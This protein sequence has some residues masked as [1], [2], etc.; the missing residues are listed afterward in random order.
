MEVWDAIHYVRFE[1]FL[2]VPDAEKRRLCRS[3]LD[4]NFCDA[5]IPK[6]MINVFQTNQQVTLQRFLSNL[7]HKKQAQRR[8]PGKDLELVLE[9]YWEE[10]APEFSKRMLR[11]LIELPHTPDTHTIWQIAVNILLNRTKENK[12][13]AVLLLEA[14]G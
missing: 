14:F 11:A 13:A 3:L 8:F 9:L 7:R 6:M 12:E 2:H 5:C 1:G 4:V 10:T